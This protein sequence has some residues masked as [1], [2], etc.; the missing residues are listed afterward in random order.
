MEK[1]QKPITFGKVMKVAFGGWKLLLAITLGVAIAGTLAIQLGF[2]RSRGVYVS[3]FSYNKA[4]LNNNMYADGSDFY[5]TEI[6]FKENLQKA[7][8]SDEK[9][10]SIDLDKIFNSNVLSFTKEIQ[11]D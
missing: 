3:T 1:E 7:I 10:K 5:Y 6:V 4:D 8:D 9:L 11:D 2:N